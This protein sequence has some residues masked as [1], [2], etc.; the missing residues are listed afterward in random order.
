MNSK[1]SIVVPIY[2]VE[3]YLDQCLESLQRQTLKEVEFICVNDGSTDKSLE[4]VNKYADKDNR[5]IIINKEN[6][7]YGKL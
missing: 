6:G 2:N 7:G 1:V 4:I 5:F 3:D